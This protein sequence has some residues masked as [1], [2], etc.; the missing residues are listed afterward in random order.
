MPAARAAAILG[1]HGYAS[2][3][4]RVG[5]TTTVWSGRS[6]RAATRGRACGSSAAGRAKAAARPACAST[7]GIVAQCAAAAAERREKVQA[8]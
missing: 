4:K 5:T 2:R 8:A 7:G 1:A 3:R 6:T